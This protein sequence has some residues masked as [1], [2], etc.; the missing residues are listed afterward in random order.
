MMRSLASRMLKEPNRIGDYRTDDY[1][2][3]GLSTRPI[4]SIALR[5]PPAMAAYATS[6][7]DQLVTGF[8][9]FGKPCSLPNGAADLL[10]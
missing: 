7:S 5:I 6:L 2:V 9:S 1:V 8:A 3:S 4:V 10:V